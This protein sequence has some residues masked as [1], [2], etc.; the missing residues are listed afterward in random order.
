VSAQAI[1]V[2]AE[3]A[4]IA[5]A[6]PIESNDRPQQHGLSGTRSAHHAKDLAAVDIEIDMVMDDGLIESIHESTDADHDV[7][8]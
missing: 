7:L 5:R 6:L 2:L 8:V 4:Y 1:D 3:D